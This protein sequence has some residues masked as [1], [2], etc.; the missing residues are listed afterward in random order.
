L[1]GVTWERPSGG[2]YVWLR[3][4]EEIEAGPSGTLFDHAMEEGVLYVPG[5]YFYCEPARYGGASTIRL[6]Y[7]VQPIERIARGIEALARA[8]RKTLG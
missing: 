8:I 6:C 4:P 7:A 3:L 1:P 5:E 2:I